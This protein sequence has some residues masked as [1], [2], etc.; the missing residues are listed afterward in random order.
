MNSKLMLKSNKGSLRYLFAVADRKLL[1][2]SPMSVYMYENVS[3]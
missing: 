3:Q 1:L 2:K